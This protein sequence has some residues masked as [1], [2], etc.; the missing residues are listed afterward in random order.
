M[1]PSPSQINA[2]SWV[3]ENMVPQSQPGGCILDKVQHFSHRVHTK[4]F[5]AQWPPEVPTDDDLPSNIGGFY[6][7]LGGKNLQQW[8]IELRKI[9]I[10]AVNK[11]D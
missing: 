4:V 1:H 2:V 6:G 3:S 9:V 7:I 8:W 10:C 5:Q 11:E